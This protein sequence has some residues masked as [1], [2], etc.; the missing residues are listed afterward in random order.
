M[1]AHRALLWGLILAVFSG[2]V[3]SLSSA[4]VMIGGL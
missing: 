2:V 1:T 3:L 4:F